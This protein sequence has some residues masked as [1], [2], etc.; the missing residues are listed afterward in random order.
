MKFFFFLSLLFLFTPFL[1]WGQISG[2]LRNEML[3]GDVKSVSKEGFKEATGGI[4]EVGK[5]YLGAEKAEKDIGFGTAGSTSGILAAKIGSYVGILLSLIGLIGV[6]Y[7][8]YGGYLWVTA[9]GNAEQ[10]KK[11]RNLIVNAVIAI[12]IVGSSYIIVAYVTG[13]FQTSFGTAQ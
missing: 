1:V 3:I 6:A 13:I 2:E 9:A 10:A 8:I 11:A 7:V 5:G 12:V 4:Q